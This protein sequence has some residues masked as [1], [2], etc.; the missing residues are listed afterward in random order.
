MLQPAR[1]A[2]KP[3]TEREEADAMAEAAR[4]ELVRQNL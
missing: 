3:R 4:K 1:S 2:P